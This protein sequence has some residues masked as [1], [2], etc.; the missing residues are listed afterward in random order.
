MDVNGS[1]SGSHKAH[2]NMT[3]MLDDSVTKS[4]KPTEA[5]SKPAVPRFSRTAG[6][7]KGPPGELPAHPRTTST[8]F[9]IVP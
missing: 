9:F 6:L 5:F 7:L 3:K 1:I 4:T 2:T 8:L